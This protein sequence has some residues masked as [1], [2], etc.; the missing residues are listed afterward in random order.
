MDDPYHTTNCCKVYNNSQLTSE[1][2]QRK[3]PLTIILLGKALQYVKQL[4]LVVI[5]ITISVH[6][7][8]VV[9]AELLV[10]GQLVFQVVKNNIYKSRLI[11]GSCSKHIPQLISTTWCRVASPLREVK[12]VKMCETK[13]AQQCSSPVQASICTFPLPRKLI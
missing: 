9:K 1:Y 5:G 10:H 6:V 12:P 7:C 13:S 2:Q 4:D 8:I 3:M 11:V